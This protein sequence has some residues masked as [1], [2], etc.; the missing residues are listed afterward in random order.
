MAVMYTVDHVRWQSCTPVVAYAAGHVNRRSHTPA[1]M[2][3]GNR[4]QLRT[5]V[6]AYSSNCICRRLRTPVVT[7]SGGRVRPWFHMSEIVYAGNRV[8]WQLCTHVL[9]QLRALA[10][11]YAGSHIH[12][13]LRTPA[14]RVSKVTCS[15]NCARCWLRRPTSYTGNHVL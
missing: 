7:C 1:V 15:S 6:A 9:R 2:F 14:T 8:H 11:T 3:S 5:L 4:I 12:W 13:Q 10:V